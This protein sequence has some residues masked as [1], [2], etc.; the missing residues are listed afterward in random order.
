MM[1][2][3]L[4]FFNFHS[5]EYTDVCKDENEKVLRFTKRCKCCNKVEYKY[6]FLKISNEE[7]KNYIKQVSNWKTIIIN[8]LR[9]EDK[10]KRILNEFYNKKK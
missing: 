1:N 5:Y 10:L 8:D 7:D 6:F 4:C 3:I 9:R 2:K